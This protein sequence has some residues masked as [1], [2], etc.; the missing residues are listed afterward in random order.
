MLKR[1]FSEFHSQK[2]ASTAQQDIEAVCHCF[3]CDKSLVIFPWGNAFSLCVV[4]VRIASQSEKLLT[5]R[6]ELTCL[7]GE[8]AIEEYHALSLQVQE[9]SRELAP[10][11][12]SSRAALQILA[13]G[14]VVLV[15]D[16]VCLS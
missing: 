15:S 3:M 4:C 7:F 11:L 2:S 13:P 12:L 5:Q 9:L 16:K 14:R 8:P 10:H 6:P 1:S